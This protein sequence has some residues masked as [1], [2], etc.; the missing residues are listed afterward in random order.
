MYQ[1]KAAIDAT[2]LANGGAAFASAD[3]WS[4]SESSSFIAWDQY[5]YGGGQ[6]NYV[7]FSALYVRAVR[8]F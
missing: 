4:S 2:A 3:Y 7:K 6:T 5:F 1:N 8:A